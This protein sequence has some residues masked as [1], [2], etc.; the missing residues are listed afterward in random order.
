MDTKP[1]I[2]NC[3][4][5]FFFVVEFTVA[6]NGESDERICIERTPT[7]VYINSFDR[8][9]R[10]SGSFFQQNEK[11]L[12]GVRSLQLATLRFTFMLYEFLVSYR[13]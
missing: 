7:E 8:H 9:L 1:A 10:K 11:G 12:R 13:L 2:K 6:G 3:F 4:S 5:A